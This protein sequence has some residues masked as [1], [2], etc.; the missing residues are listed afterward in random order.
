MMSRE[1]ENNSDSEHKERETGRVRVNN[2]VRDRKHK[3]RQDI[4]TERRKKIKRE[5]DRE[6]GVI[7]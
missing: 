1:R 6:R 4:K 3:G 5:C 7:E 2:R